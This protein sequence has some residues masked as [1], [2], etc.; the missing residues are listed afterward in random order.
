MFTDGSIERWLAGRSQ[1]YGPYDVDLGLAV[2]DS[3]TAGVLLVAGML[4]VTVFEVLSLLT[5]RSARFRTM[6]LVVLV[7]FHVST[8]LLMN[9]FFWENLVLLAVLFTGSIDRL[10]DARKR[11]RPRSIAWP[12]S[13]SRSSGVR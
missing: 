10:P 2:M 13:S 1:Q 11:F 5:L 6:W 7:S 9:I 4:V 8:L 3:P 12:F